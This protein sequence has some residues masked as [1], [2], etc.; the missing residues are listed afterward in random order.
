MRLAAS[1]ALLVSLAGCQQDFASEGDAL[2]R[3]VLELQADNERLGVRVSELEAALDRAE[4][5]PDE[6]RADVRAA[7]PHVADIELHRLC[8]VDDTD[9]DGRP[10]LL[11]VYVQPT[12]GRGRFV[13]LAGDLTVRADV[14]GEGA[15]SLE[16]ASATLD[17][18]ELRD[19][20]RSGV[21][22]THYTIECPLEWPAEP[23]DLFVRAVYT[24]G[25]TARKYATERTVTV[26]P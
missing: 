2:R 6:W 25:R 21:L 7:A 9:G 22:G 12:D 11:R 4:R 19:A 18:L 17:P 10:D 23:Q 26:Q 8:H 16:V 5:R 24:D 1:L 13:Q 14:L 20:Y 3:Q 15:T